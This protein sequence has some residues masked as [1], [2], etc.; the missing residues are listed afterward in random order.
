MKKRIN[1]NLLLAKSRTNIN[2]FGLVDSILSISLLAGIITYGVYFSSL[3][4]STVHSSNLIRSVNKEIERDIERLKLDLWSLFYNKEKG[5]YEFSD[6][7]CSEIAFNIINLPSWNTQKNTIGEY[8]QSWRPGKERSKVFS[9]NKILISRE[10]SVSPPVNDQ[11]LN[12]SIGTIN[13]R[14]EWGLENKHWLSIDLGAE[15]H[16]WCK[17][18]I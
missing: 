16:S 3:R 2:G 17:Q 6:S 14:V 9:G 18:M 10:L 5:K 13:Y 8:S 15:A 1:K 7:E 4:L 11:T 12:N